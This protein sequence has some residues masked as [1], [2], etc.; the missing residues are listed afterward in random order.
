MLDHDSPR[1]SDVTYDNTGGWAPA[2]DP[3]QDAKCDELIEIR[4]EERRAE[5]NLCPHERLNEDGICR[6]C[7]SDCRGIGGGA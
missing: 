7:G 6:R 4:A 2:D 5:S 1:F 3:E